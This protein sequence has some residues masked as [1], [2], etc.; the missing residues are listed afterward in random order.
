LLFSSTEPKVHG[1]GGYSS[2]LWNCWA[3]LP[4]IW[5]VA[6]LWQSHLNV[7]MPC[8]LAPFMGSTE[9]KIEKPFKHLLLLNLMMDDHQ[10]LSVAFLSSLLILIWKIEI[11]LNMISY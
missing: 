3:D 1:K 4:Q 9:L 7:L 8:H 5:S 2:V 6:S 11:P 10:N